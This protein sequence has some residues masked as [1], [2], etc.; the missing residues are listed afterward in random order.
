MLHFT[1]PYENIISYDA[2]KQKTAR[3]VVTY[4]TM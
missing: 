1:Y 4:Y 2:L 3:T